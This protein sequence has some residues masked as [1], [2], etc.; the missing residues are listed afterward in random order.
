MRKEDFT[1]DTIYKELFAYTLHRNYPNDEMNEIGGSHVSIEGLVEIEIDSVKES[2][3]EFVVDGSASLEITTDLG[4]GDVYPDTYPMTFSYVFDSNGKIVKQLSREIDTSS[5]FAGSEDVYGDFVGA[6]GSTQSQ[7][8]QDSLT[9]IHNLLHRPDTPGK[10]IRQL[11]YVHVITALETYLSDFLSAKVL[12][13]QTSIRNFIEKAPIFQNQKLSVSE[14]F[15][16]IESIKKRVMHT[17]EKVNWHNL[18]DVGMLYDR[19][20]DISLPSDLTRIEDSIRLRNLLVH[21]NGKLLD[22][23]EREVS[24]Q[25][26]LDA[27]HAAEALVNHIEERWHQLQRRPEPPPEF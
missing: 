7:F 24:E 25:D 14:V 21:R 2:G 11:L 9:D 8:F 18:A 6:I 15:K 5:F 13:D 22:G 23:T 19:A 27:M 12:N 20:L 4:E 3:T 10:F 26:V 17:L 1:P 16:A